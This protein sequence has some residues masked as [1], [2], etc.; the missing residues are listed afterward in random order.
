MKRFLYLFVAGL[1]AA[2]GV[3]ASLQAFSYADAG[4][5]LAFFGWLALAAVMFACAYLCLEEK[6]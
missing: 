2:N 3:C 4:P 6:R 1:A 5:R